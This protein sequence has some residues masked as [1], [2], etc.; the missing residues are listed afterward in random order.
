MLSF[1]ISERVALDKLTNRNHLCGF[2]ETYKHTIISSF[3]ILRKNLEKNSKCYIIIILSTPYHCIYI[4]MPI[5]CSYKRVRVSQM[6][7]WDK[8]P[9]HDVQLVS[10]VISFFNEFPVLLLFVS[11]RYFNNVHCTYWW[12]IYLNDMLCV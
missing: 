11:Y 7:S 4:I 9:H 12:H 6:I 3:E 1:R 8:K 5:Y 2:I 10:R